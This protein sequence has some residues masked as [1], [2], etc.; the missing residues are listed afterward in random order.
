MDPRGSVERRSERPIQSVDGGSAV[1]TGGGWDVL[2]VRF[3]LS[4]FDHGPTTHG[5]FS[6]VT[7]TFHRTSRSTLPTHVSLYSVRKPLPTS[8]D[9]LTLFEKDLSGLIMVL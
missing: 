1:L 4:F 7:Q 8:L 2:S 9:L 3:F 5:L 6:F